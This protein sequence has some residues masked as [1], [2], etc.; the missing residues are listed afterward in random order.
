MPDEAAAAAAAAA[1]LAAFL[2]FLVAA[3]ER[4]RALTGK[5]TVGWALGR[6]LRSVSLRFV[7][8]RRKGRSRL[9]SAGRRT[10]EKS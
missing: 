5:S 2:D 9:K 6:A 8:T 7:M 3:L 10:C 4:R 1:A